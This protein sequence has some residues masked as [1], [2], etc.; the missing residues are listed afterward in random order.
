M[1]LKQHHCFIS[2]LSIIKDDVSTRDFRIGVLVFTALQWPLWRLH[3]G[4]VM[5]SSLMD[6]KLLGCAQS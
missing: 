1:F 4:E 2:Y 5:Q 3:P 6:L